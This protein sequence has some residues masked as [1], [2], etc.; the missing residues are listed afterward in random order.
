MKSNKFAVVVAGLAIAAFMLWLAM[1]LV[2][3][4]PKT[5]R[6]IHFDPQFRN[7]PSLDEAIKK[8][9]AIRGVN[10]NDQYEAD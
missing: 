3:L 1:S 9:S 4:Q 10:P 8:M 6:E 2:E 5:L 7:G